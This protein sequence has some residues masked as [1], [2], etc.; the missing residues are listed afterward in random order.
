MEPRTC[1]HKTCG[2]VWTPR[3]ANPKKCP[4]CGNSL[5]QSPR[6]KTIKMVPPSE[7]DVFVNASEYDVMSS[8]DMNEDPPVKDTLSEA[9]A[10]AEALLRQLA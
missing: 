3:K 2:N 8:S 6:P 5:W 7:G 10:R 9:K 1:P 4:Q